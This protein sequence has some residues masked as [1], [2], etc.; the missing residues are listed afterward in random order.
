MHKPVCRVKSNA[1]KAKGADLE[2]LSARQ[3]VD[4]GMRFFRK[5]RSDAKA[6]AE[7]RAAL[8]GV[9]SSHLLSQIEVATTPQKKQ[10][11]DGSA[12]DSEKRYL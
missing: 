7:F 5:S 10:V 4:R 11:S 6:I 2:A 1:L 3:R 12:N 9:L 8:C